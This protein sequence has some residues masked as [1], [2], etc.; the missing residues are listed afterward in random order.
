MF[1][2]SLIVLV[3]ATAIAAW[4]IAF[5][6]STHCDTEPVLVLHHPPKPGTCS[7]IHGHPAVKSYS[8]GT[9]DNVQSI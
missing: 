4:P 8:G 5:Y 9:E 2:R 7:F 3:A 1:A 6:P